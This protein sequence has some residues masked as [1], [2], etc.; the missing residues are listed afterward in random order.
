[1]VFLRG[2]PGTT[3]ASTSFGFTMVLR[4]AGL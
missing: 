3:P 4:G 2:L 1:M